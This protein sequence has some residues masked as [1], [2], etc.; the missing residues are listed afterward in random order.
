MAYAPDPTLFNRAFGGGVGIGSGLADLVRQRQQRS[1]L[2]ELAQLAQQGDYSGLGAG[3]IEQGQVGAG[4]NALGVP[5]AR[6]QDAAQQ[7]FQRE[8][9]AARQANQDRSFNADEAHRAAQLGMD[10]ERLAIARQN[11]ARGG[12]ENLGLNPLFVEGPNGEMGV[13]QLGNRGTVREVQFPDGTKPLGPY[14]K[15]FES[16]RGREAGKSTGEAQVDYQRVVDNASQMQSVI[17]QALTHP[18]LENATGIIEGRLPARNQDIQDFRVLVDQ[19]RGKTFLEAFNSL[20]GGGQITETEGRKA[21][22][23]IA[24]LNLAQSESAFRAALGELKSIVDTGVQR[25]AKKAGGGGAPSVQD[26]PL[27]LFK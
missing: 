22:D 24:R 17:D 10:R 25:A 18:A 15:S 16:S 23:A 5:Y 19:I 11:A 26:D 9:F 2:A 7:A 14:E 13:Y 27:G 6:E 3:L 12:N 8:Q 21:T 1:H 4:I 20:R